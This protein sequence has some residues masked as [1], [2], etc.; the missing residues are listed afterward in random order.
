MTILKTYQMYTLK[1]INWVNYIDVELSAYYKW[2]EAGRPD[3]RDLE[4]W[5]AAEKEK[6]IVVFKRK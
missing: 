1:N 6:F 5:L 2:E 3:G 4:F